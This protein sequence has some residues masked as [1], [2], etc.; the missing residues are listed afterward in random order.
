MDLYRLPRIA[1]FG[2]H[3]LD[4]GE[5]LGYDVV[6]LSDHDSREIVG[7]HDAAVGAEVDELR[8]PNAAVGDMRRAA[9]EPAV[10]VLFAASQGTV[11]KQPMTA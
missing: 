8:T 2:L 3:R 9:A 6:D 7:G 11:D 5:H 1:G 10:M 4:A